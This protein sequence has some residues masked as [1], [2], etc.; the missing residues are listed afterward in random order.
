MNPRPFRFILFDLD[1]TLYPRS[2]GL[3]RWIH[4]RMDEWIIAHLGIE[5]QE[6]PALRQRL[7]REYGTSMSG[8]LAEYHIDADDFLHYVHDFDPGAL[9][10][11]NPALFQAIERIPLRR[12]IFTNGTQAHAR[13][14][15]DALGLT[16]L[17]ERIIDV[18]DV[19]YVSKPAPQAYQRALALLQ[20]TP[21]TCILVEDSVRNLIPA[22]SMG[23]ATI[24]V[25][26]EPHPVA[27]YHLS[28]VLEVTDAVARL[29]RDRA[30]AP[31]ASTPPSEHA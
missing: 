31:N 19:G 30:S 17:F 14:V 25:G 20:A 3:M 9:L 11:P 7:Y 29:I 8:L 6:A 23:M 24:L 26:G 21:E 28:D 4:Q 10:Q 18:V 16:P 22:K 13:R 1:D 5:Q 12:V 27:D 15:L 2:A